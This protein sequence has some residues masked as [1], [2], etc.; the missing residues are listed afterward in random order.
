MAGM[1]DRHTKVWLLVALVVSGAMSSAWR[2]TMPCCTPSEV[3]AAD[4]EMP[5]C[6]LGADVDPVEQP[7]DEAPC[8]SDDANCPRPCCMGLHVAVPSPILT[9]STWPAPTSRAEFAVDQFI[10][11][12][13]AL[14]LIKPPKA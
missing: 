4:R 12:D 6:C 13:V 1:F 11:R 5:A 7:V 2:L 14:D 8:H 9:G 10:A 3:V